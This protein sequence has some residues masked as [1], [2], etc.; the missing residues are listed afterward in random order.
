MDKKYEDHYVAF[1]DVL[2]FKEMLDSNAA[3]EEICAVFESLQKNAHSGLSVDG[4]KVPAFD[5]VKYYL[6]SDSII[7]YIKAD[8]KDSLVALIGTC[9]K[10]QTKL[11]S[12]EHPILLRGGIARGELFVDERVIFGKGLSAAYQ[13]ESSVA[14]TPRIVFNKDLLVNGRE[15]CE[16]LGQSWWEGMLTR[17]DKDELYYVHYLALPY[18]AKIN[19]TPAVFEKILNLCQQYLDRTYIKSLRDKYLWLKEYALSELRLQKHII[20]DQPGG[21]ELVSKWCIR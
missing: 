12:R 19:D 18:M 6:M 14:V 3:C 21:W 11:V 17:K 8:L 20:K 9:L 1:I 15:N 16:L 7:L 4:Q 13:L 5:E 10:L 2:G